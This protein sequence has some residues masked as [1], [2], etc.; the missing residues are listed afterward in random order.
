L[1]GLG[2]VEKEAVVGG[3]RRILEYE[4]LFDALRNDVVDQIDV[5]ERTWIRQALRRPSRVLI[6]SA[7]L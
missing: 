5:R 4:G 7:L 1:R 2:D 6:S 3:G